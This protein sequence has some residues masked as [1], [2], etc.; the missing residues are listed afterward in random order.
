MAALTP[1]EAFEAFV[2]GSWQGPVLGIN[3]LKFRDQADYPDDTYSPCTGREAWL[4]YEEQAL[5]VAEK[6]RLAPVIRATVEQ[7]LQPAYGEEWDAVIINR[8][9][10]K[11]NLV[12]A[13][14]D[15]ELAAL[16]VHVGAAIEQYTFIARRPDN[17]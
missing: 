11:Q 17:I 4:R 15:Q 16:G 14:T 6:Y 1:E 13:L 9:P 7:T 8:Y 3:L 2:Q 12:D 10:E 5:V